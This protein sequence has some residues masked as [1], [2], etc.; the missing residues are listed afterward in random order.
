MQMARVFLSEGV[1]DPVHARWLA[2]FD[3]NFDHIEAPRDLAGAQKPQPF[4]RAPLDESP[5]ARVHGVETADFRPH[6]AGF[7]LHE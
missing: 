5:F 7:H 6:A 3:G 1:L 4:I 2:V